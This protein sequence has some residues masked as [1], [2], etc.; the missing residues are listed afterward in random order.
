MGS[1]SYIFNALVVSILLFLELPLFDA[2]LAMPKC[3]LHNDKIIN[4]N[5]K[6]LPIPYTLNDVFSIFLS[7]DIWL[8]ELLGII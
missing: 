3:C 2:A 5:I 6:S 1:R 8:L 7:T 4:K